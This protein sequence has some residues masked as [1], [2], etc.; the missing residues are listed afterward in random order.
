[1]SEANKR[2]VGGEHYRSKMQHWDIVVEHELN[3]FEAQILR[4]VMRARKKAGLQD[5]QKAAH[6][7]EKY[8]EEWPRLNAL[9]AEVVRVLPRT[10]EEI[11]KE[12]QHQMELASHFWADGFTKEGTRYQCRHCK[13]VV[14]AQSPV[15][16]AALHTQPCPLPRP[17][18]AV[19]ALQEAAQPTIRVQQPAVPPAKP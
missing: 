7:I 8:M 12:Y 3:Y 5:L 9:P 6:F 18:M 19:Q 16:A 15:G 11:N 17:S 4:Y 2:Q 13:A 10:A 14:T 1:M